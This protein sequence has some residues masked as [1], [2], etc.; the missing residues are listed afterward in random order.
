[1]VPKC[2]FDSNPLENYKV[3]ERKKQE[4]YKENNL[5]L[6]NRGFFPLLSLLGMGRGP[7][8]DIYLCISLPLIAH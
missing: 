7:F 3:D 8:G 5:I 2:I 6:I 4:V 1:M